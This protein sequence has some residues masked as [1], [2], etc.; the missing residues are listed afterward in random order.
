MFIRNRY[1]KYIFAIQKK[2]H[3]INRPQ[4]ITSQTNLGHLKDL[5]ISKFKRKSKIGMPINIYRFIC[6]NCCRIW[7][8]KFKKARVPQL[9]SCIT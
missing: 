5:E 2:Q 3:I 4:V 8:S 6:V 7:L 1:L 9:G